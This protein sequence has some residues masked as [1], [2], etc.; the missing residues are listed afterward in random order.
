MSRVLVLGASGRI[1]RLAIP[2]LAA[3]GHDLTLL[4]RDPSGLEQLA[5]GARLVRGDVLDPEVLAGAV[6]GQDLVYGNLAGEVDAQAA[7]IVAAMRSAGVTRLIFVASLGIYDEVPGAFGEWN[8]QQ[9]GSMLVPYRAAADLI[10][11]SDLDW[12]ILRPAWLTDDDEV[13]FETTA[14]GEPFRGTVVSRR[15]VAA[16]VTQI[17]DDP[18]RHVRE[19]VGVDKPGTDG[20]RP[21]TG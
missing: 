19:S 4:A 15:S 11:A 9:I 20:D 16:L 21:A 3:A 10:E 1:A 14:K 17:A 2:M 18:A 7:A 12:T 13:A 8:R 5:P 6:A